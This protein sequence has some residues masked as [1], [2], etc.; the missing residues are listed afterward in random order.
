MRLPWRTGVR[1]CR[2]PVGADALPVGYVNHSVDHSVEPVFG[3]E[4][5]ADSLGPERFSGLEV[6]GVQV[7]CHYVGVYDAIG[8]CHI[9][10]LPVLVQAPFLLPG[11]GLDPVEPR[12]ACGQDHSVSGAGYASDA[13]LFK[14]PE[15]FS[16]SGVQGGHGSIDRHRP[17]PVD[18][19]QRLVVDVI[20]RVVS[21]DF[22]PGLPQEFPC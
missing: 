3:S 20:R 5:E 14:G 1:G 15:A 12:V 21:G 13:V 7:A 8:H 19:I 4:I 17:Y 22:P 18:D 10:H 2:R 11:C 16:C 9:E 6:Q